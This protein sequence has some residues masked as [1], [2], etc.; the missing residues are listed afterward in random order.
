MASLI[1]RA[2]SP[3]RTVVPPYGSRPA[4]TR[5][6]RTRLSGASTRFPGAG[7]AHYLVYPAGAAKA[8]A[9]Y[10][11]RPSRPLRLT[12]QAC[13]KKARAEYGPTNFVA[14]WPATLNGGMPLSWTLRPCLDT[15]GPWIAELRAVVLRHDLER[16]GRFDPVRVRRRF[17]D[18]FRP[19]LTQSLTLTAGTPV[20]F[21]FV[22]NR[23]PCGL[24][25]SIWNRPST[26]KE[27]AVKCC[28][29]SGRCSGTSG[30]FA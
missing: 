30:R 22:R 10:T 25:T 5:V 17:L 16:L 1:R 21:R 13:P 15:D 8:H 24:S 26:G 2:A 18:Q 20:P 4:G 7:S 6:I 28:A 23:A 9:E 29:R 12:R 14:L 3:G 27:L 19:E 11:E